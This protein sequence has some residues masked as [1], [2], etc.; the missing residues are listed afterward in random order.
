MTRS[1]FEDHITAMRALL[2]DQG[3][4]RVR[5]NFEKIPELEATIKARDQ[6]IVELKA[7]LEQQKSTHDVTHQKSL[8]NY[9]T[10]RDQLNAQ[11]EEA[12]NSA[13]SLKEKLGISHTEISTFKGNE[14]GLKRTIDQLNQSWKRSEE[15]A[16]KAEA[17]FKEIIQKQRAQLSEFDSS[18]KQHQSTAKQLDD[19]RS[20]AI[21]LSDEGFQ[22]L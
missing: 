17:N 2:S 21:T 16:K 18:K 7:K 13:A 20:L 22:P 15:A 6:E 4:E 14:A 19:I 1:V 9:N 8:Q 11:L 10:D 3:L 12:R 5:I